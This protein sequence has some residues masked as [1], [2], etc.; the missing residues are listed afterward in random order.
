MRNQTLQYS[1][2]SVRL[3]KNTQAAKPAWERLPKE[4]AAQPRL[5]GQVGDCPGREEE[6]QIGKGVC[7]GQR[8]QFYTKCLE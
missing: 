2:G 5:E 6:E 8:E 7:F 1:V 4:M 3:R